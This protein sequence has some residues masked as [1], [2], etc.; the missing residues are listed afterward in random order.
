MPH[1]FINCLSGQLGGVQH[2]WYQGL[3]SRLIY[4]PGVVCKMYCPALVNKSRVRKGTL[5]SISKNIIHGTKA[6]ALVTKSY[7]NQDKGPISLLL[8]VGQISCNVQSLYCTICG[9][10]LF[11]SVLLSPL[12]HFRMTILCLLH[13][14]SD[15]KI[16]TS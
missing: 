15:N 6:A 1:T 12:L 13:K 3:K 5:A 2:K 11:I 4:L 7:S 8:T 16:E 10:F 14:F 9:I